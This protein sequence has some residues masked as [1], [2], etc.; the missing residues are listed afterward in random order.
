MLELE[1]KIKIF[2][3]EKGEAYEDILDLEG[4]VNNLN[5][6]NKGWNLTCS[7]L[8]RKSLDY[9]KQIKEL[10][11]NKRKSISMISQGNSKFEK[12]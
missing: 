8:T 7:Q 6:R 12:C 4:Q 2:E 5:E 10:E 3:T 11:E 1:E 9:L